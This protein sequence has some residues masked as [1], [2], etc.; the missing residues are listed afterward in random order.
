MK[1]PHWQPPA[2]A[3]LSKTNR[4]DY[5]LLLFL[6][7]IFTDTTSEMVVTLTIEPSFSMQ[8]VI[9]WAGIDKIGYQSPCCW[10]F[11]KQNILIKSSTPLVE[12]L[13]Q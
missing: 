12:A 2:P 6:F 9:D 1:H 13:Y 11:A 4:Y 3:C 10:S 7:I 5:N 8:M